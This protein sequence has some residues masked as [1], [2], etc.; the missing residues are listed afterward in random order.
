M[1][2]CHHHDLSVHHLS[3]E[4]IFINICRR[5]DTE[6]MSRVWSQSCPLSCLIWFVHRD[7]HAR[8]REGD[9]V[10]SG[11][12]CLGHLPGERDRRRDEWRRGR[13]SHHLGHARPV[14]PALSQNC[15][16]TPRHH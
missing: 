8:G 3:L 5:D 6:K 2:P 10:G 15:R 13:M 1:P 16:F 14:V 11:L 7:R 12:S 9:L 4:D